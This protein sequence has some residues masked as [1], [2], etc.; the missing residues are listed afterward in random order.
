MSNYKF[1]A[2]AWSEYTH[3]PFQAHYYAARYDGSV[4]HSTDWDVFFKETGHYTSKMV[5]QIGHPKKDEDREVYRNEYFNKPFSKIYKCEMVVGVKFWKEEELYYY[6]S[7]QDPEEKYWAA[8][9]TCAER[10]S[11]D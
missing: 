7:E 2:F 1:Y 3:N 6:S 10:F 4:F 8:V 11:G 9:A 5:Y